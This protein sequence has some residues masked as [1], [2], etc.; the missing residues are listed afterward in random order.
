M[1]AAYHERMLSIYP[2][3]EDGTG[4]LSIILDGRR[5]VI[6]GDP[7]HG[8]R[9][10]H[11][12]TDTQERTHE[13]RYQFDIGD[14]PIARFRPID[15]E[16]DSVLPPDHLLPWPVLMEANCTRLDLVQLA[17]REFT[18]RAKSAFSAMGTQG[19]HQM[20]F[21]MPPKWKSYVETETWQLANRMY[22]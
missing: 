6:Y 3:P 8:R 5:L 22:S 12:P 4:P 10:S 15:V 11:I 7:D 14:H 17:T 9:P 16:Y 2:D 13:W 21:A 18:M 1:R 19:V 20:L